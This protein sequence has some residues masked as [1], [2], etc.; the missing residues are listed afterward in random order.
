MCSD[1]KTPFGI[2]C[3]IIFLIYIIAFCIIL[4]K[5]TGYINPCC[6]N[7]TQSCTSCSNCALIINC[8]YIIVLSLLLFALL[9]ILFLIFKLFKEVCS[10]ISKS[11][12]E[13]LLD[14]LKKERPAREQ[15]ATS[16]S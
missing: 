16:H 4:C 12:W 10:F 13:E 9:A 15:K 8:D 7:I 2:F 5:F 14:E 3:S 6:M 1:T 11:Q